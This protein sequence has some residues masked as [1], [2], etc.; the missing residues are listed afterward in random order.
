VTIF[1]RIV[2]DNIDLERTARIQ[3]HKTTNKSLHCFQV[4]G[5]KDRVS[6]KNLLSDQ[7]QKSLADLKKKEFLPTAHVHSSV[8]NDLTGLIPRIIII[9]YLPA[10]DTSHLLKL[11]ISTSHMFIPQKWLKYLRWYV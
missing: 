9:Q 5:V 4:Y 11:F 1:F 10:Q 8:I 7:S 2:G 6:F 3:A